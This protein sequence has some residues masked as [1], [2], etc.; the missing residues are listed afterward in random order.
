MAPP[1]A[2]PASS[3]QEVTAA[4]E[5]TLS[6]TPTPTPLALNGGAIVGTD[7]AFSPNDGDTPSGGQGQTVGNVACLSSMYTNN[8]HVHFF[9]GILVNKHQ[10]ALPDAIG[11]YK[12]GS[13]SGGYTNNAQCYYALHTHDASGMV[14]VESSSTASLSSSVFNLGQ[15]LAVWGEPISS[16]GFG[17]FSGPV[18]VFVAHPPL[19]AT[20]SGPYTAYT[21]DPHAIPIYSHE[22]I[23]IEVGT[24]YDSAS[25]LPQVRFYTEY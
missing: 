18:H 24:S 2:Q 21:G 9:L 19:R 13:E 22:A 8:Y 5:T 14:H 7:N 25:E 10:Y 11:L 1:V 12:Y 4:Q 23:W 3:P 15:F 20:Y 17:P 16:S 6:V